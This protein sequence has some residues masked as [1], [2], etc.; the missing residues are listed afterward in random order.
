MTLLSNLNIR[1]VD[2][3]ANSAN[4]IA[5]DPNVRYVSLDAPIRSNGHVTT[6]TGAQQVRSQSSALGLNNSLD[7]SGVTIA[8]LGSGR[9]P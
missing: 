1:I 4:V 8:I 6:T 5:A 2:A 9:C 7:G 3:A